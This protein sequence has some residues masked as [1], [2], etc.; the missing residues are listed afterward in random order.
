[1]SL[2]YVALGSNLQHPATQVTSAFNALDGLPECKLLLSS[3]LY[4][5]PPLGYENQPDFINAV[6][7]L[8]TT[9]TPLELLKKLL[10]I[11]TA[12][13]RERTF[14][15]APR[16]LDLDL[17]LYDDLVMNTPT[18]TLPHPRLHER[19]FVLFPLAEIAPD[20]L[21]PKLGSVADLLVA[22]QD[23]NIEKLSA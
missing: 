8:E 2:A 14:P 13:G 23:E 4:K 1:M 11:E 17:L 18:L 19:G 12:Q 16:V 5:T 9:L 20:L 22:C 10:V 7:M 3:S 15:N 6:A 21:I